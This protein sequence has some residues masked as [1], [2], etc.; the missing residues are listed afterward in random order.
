MA[1][2]MAP[3]VVRGQ[4][5]AKAAA[6]GV[7]DRAMTRAARQPVLLEREPWPTAP[8]LPPMLDPEG[9]TVGL[10]MPLWCNVCRAKHVGYQ[11][12]PIPAARKRT[13]RGKRK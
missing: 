13:R 9:D 8:E 4:R 12:K 10:L 2:K 1:K 7:E 11:C 3:D 6:R 5:Q